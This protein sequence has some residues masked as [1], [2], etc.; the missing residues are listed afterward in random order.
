MRGSQ[1]I[2]LED[3]EEATASKFLRADSSLDQELQQIPANARRE[4]KNCTNTCKEKHPTPCLQNA[5]SP[6]ALF[7]FKVPAGF[8]NWSLSKMRSQN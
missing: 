8:C 1:I 7:H 5:S 2:A 6:T 3:D 4:G